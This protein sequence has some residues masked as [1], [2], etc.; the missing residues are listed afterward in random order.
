VRKGARD[1]YGL[2]ELPDRA[3]LEAIAEP[4]APYRSVASWYLWRATERVV[5]A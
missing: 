5:P 1:L 3:A 4:W 2:P